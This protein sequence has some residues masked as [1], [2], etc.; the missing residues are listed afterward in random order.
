MTTREEQQEQVLLDKLYVRGQRLWHLMESDG[1][2]EVLDILEGI[3][4]GA[5]QDLLNYRGTDEKLLLGLQKRSLAYRTLFHQFQ[6]VVLDTVEV[7]KQV[8]LVATETPLPGA[9]EPIYAGA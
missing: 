8:P 6:Q 9:S 5:E 7:A 4:A 2:P 3:V 1:W